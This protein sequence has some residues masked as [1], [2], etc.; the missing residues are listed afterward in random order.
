MNVGENFEIS[1][2][3][4]HCS[5]NIY[6]RIFVGKENLM[7]TQSICEFCPFTYELVNDLELVTCVFSL[8]H[9]LLL[10]LTVRFVFANKFIY[11]FFT[12]LYTQF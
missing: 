10:L 12:F 9:Y 8:S 2:S 4:V 7:I 5:K 1:N 11:S 3:T 6:K